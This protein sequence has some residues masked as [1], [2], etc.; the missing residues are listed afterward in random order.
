MPYSVMTDEIKK[1]YHGH[2]II[3][4]RLSLTMKG[5]H[6]RRLMLLSVWV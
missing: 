6:L 1:I 4:L 5:R 2:D 3:R